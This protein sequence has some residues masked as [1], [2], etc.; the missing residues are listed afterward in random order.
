MHLISAMYASKELT[1]SSIPEMLVKNLDRKFLKTL[2]NVNKFRSKVSSTQIG[3][4]KGGTPFQVIH[5][6]Q[7]GN[8]DPRRVPTQEHNLGGQRNVQCAPPGRIGP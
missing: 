2:D 1:N 5:K 7:Q 4:S 6:V 8:S 3:D